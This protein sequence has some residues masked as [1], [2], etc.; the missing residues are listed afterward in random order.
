MAV[1]SFDYSKT[2]S[3]V[4]IERYRGAAAIVDVPYNIAGTNVTKIAAKAFAGCEEIKRINIPYCVT[5]I[6]IDAFAGCTQLKEIF[7]YNKLIKLGGNSIKLN[8]NEMHMPKNFFVREDFKEVASPVPVKLLKTPVEDFCYSY[9]ADGITIEEYRGSAEVVVV[10]PKIDGLP[11]AGIAFAAFGGC[12]SL[13][14][15][16]LPEGLTFINWRALDGCRNLQAVY[17]PRTLANEPETL[18]LIATLP[19]G[20]EVLYT[21]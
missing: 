1:V 7:W 13:K 2:A 11:V 16:H 18:R 10:P 20:C 15:L 5:E 6:E 17:I 8:G 14:E 4:T 3:G 9:G 12:L 19:E 21:S